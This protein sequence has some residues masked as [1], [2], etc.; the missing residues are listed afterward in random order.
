MLFLLSLTL[1]LVN[2]ILT[3]D[4]QADQIFGIRPVN[5]SIPT[6]GAGGEA[7]SDLLPSGQDNSVINGVHS[8][9]FTYSGQLESIQVTY[10]LSNGSLY[11]A[12]RHGGNTL[13]NVTITFA[14][15]EYIERIT[16][17]S[18]GYIVEQVYVRTVRKSKHQQI[19]YGPFGQSG[20]GYFAM[21]GFVVSF[22]GRAGDCVDRLGAYTLAPLQQSGFFG[23]I[24]GL[25]FDEN[26]DSFFPTPAVKVTKIFVSWS[27]Y[28]GISVQLEYLL[29][30]S[31]TKLGEWHGKPGEDVLVIHVRDSEV[32]SSV[33]G[34]TTQYGLESLAFIT[35]KQDGSY[36]K[37]GP[38]GKSDSNDSKPFSVH[39][40]VMGFAGIAG[41]VLSGVRVY[42]I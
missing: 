42:Y 16:G 40:Y 8:M 5:S 1:V 41:S 10:K 37:H 27:Y 12:P 28:T 31:M 26:P 21:N 25:D 39:G 29:L 36:I 35:Q 17:K 20:T 13:P 34:T 14:D 4:V 22:F 9:T 2:L 19:Y 15:D 6:G 30:N 24:D 11:K 7:F 3:A 33:E 18:S 23:G 32:L 38:F